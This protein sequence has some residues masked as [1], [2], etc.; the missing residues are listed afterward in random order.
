M[1]SVAVLA[2]WFHSYRIRTAHPQ[3]P[4]ARAGPRAMR[5]QLHTLHTLVGE[6]QVRRSSSPGHQAVAA[7]PGGRGA[8]DEGGRHGCLHQTGSERRRGGRRCCRCRCCRRRGIGR[9]ERLA[10]RACW[11]PPTSYSHT[12]TFTQSHS[13]TVTQS[14][15]LTHSH[16][17]TSYTALLH[18][19]TPCYFIQCRYFIHNNQPQAHWLVLLLAAYRAKFPVRCTAVQPVS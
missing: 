5:Q 16:S 15:T 3:G 14:H 11:L 7:M 9:H 18:T 19:R 17:V 13:H 1:A 2:P 4:N 12:H 10:G 8:R 6:P